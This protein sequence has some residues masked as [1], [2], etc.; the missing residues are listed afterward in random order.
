M[1]KCSLYTCQLCNT[2]PH[3]Q[4]PIFLVLFQLHETPLIE[5][6]ASTIV[7]FHAHGLGKIRRLV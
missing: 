2:H 7:K 1:A 3:K 6:T 4:P 5:R